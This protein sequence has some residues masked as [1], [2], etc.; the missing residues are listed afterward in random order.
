MGR[1]LFSFK[2]EQSK[3]KVPEQHHDGEDM[4]TNNFNLD[5]EL[6]LDINCN[7]VSVLPY[8]YDQVMDVEEIEETDEAEMAKHRPVCYCVMN[9]GV[10]EE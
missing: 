4:L 7:V 9:N 1:T 8:E 5:S 6:T 2:G 10:V 3:V